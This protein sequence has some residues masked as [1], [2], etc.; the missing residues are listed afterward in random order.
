MIETVFG[1]PGLGQLTVF[2]VSTVDYPV[3]Q[4]CVMIA[5]FGFVVINLAAD[6][7]VVL[8]NPRLR[9]ETFR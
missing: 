2:A 4:A 1:F 6:A 7:L 3:I 9:R 8:T 5:A